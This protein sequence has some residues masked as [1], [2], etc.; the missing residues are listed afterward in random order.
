[1]DQTNHPEGGQRQDNQAASRLL[2]PFLY[3][4]QELKPF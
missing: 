2:C 4:W 1:M 3:I